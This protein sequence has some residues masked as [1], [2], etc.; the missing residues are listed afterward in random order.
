MKTMTRYFSFSS[1][2]VLLVTSAFAQTQEPSGRVY[3][4]SA[5]MNGNQVMTVFGNWGVIGQPEEMGYRGAWKYPN[6]GYLGDVSPLVGAEVRY[7]S[8]YRNGQWVQTPNS[9]FHSVV[10]CPVNRPT[11]L[12]D[13]GPDGTYWTFEP[14]AGYFNPS[15]TNQKVAMSDD[16]NSWPPSWPDK[17]QDATDPGWPGSW[18]GYFGKNKMSADLETYY[19]MDDNNDIRF[20]FPRGSDY[21]GA[22]IWSG[23]QAG[24]NKSQ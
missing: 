20:N 3:Q 6:N 13:Q 14:E 12:T 15:S 4:R 11:T 16:K 19:V 1:L 7:D 18:N 21:Q 17:M 2:I 23:I 8:A 5:I 24:F 10:T 9:V 22:G